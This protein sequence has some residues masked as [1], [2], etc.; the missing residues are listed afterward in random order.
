MASSQT[1]PDRSPKDSGVKFPQDWLVSLATTPLLITI[2]GTKVAYQMFINFTSSS[3]EIFRGDRL[4]V[5]HFP[6]ADE[7]GVVKK[8]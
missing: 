8:S 3:E 7:L 5:L 4:P 6:Q 1:D 2:L